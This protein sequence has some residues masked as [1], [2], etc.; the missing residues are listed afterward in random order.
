MLGDG[1]QAGLSQSARI[2]RDA[3]STAVDNR[4]V[5]DQRALPGCLIVTGV[6]GAGKT[7]TT[8]LVARRLR[9]AARIDGDD[10][11]MMIVSGNVGPVSEPADEAE[12]QLHLRA[13]N[14]CSLANN[15][16]AA[17]FAPIVDH[18][19]PDRAVLQL[20]IDNL[21][22]RPVMLVLL[23]PPLSV[24]ERRNVTRD[25][26]EQVDYDFSDLY[27]SMHAEFSGVGWTVDTSHIPPDVVAD[28]ILEQASQRAGVAGRVA[29]EPGWFSRR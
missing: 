8:R 26:Q 14:I 22:P 25:P 11:A 9:R 27:R 21:Q 6:P 18:V 7:T 17:G 13:R 29:R 3:S 12:R 28:A 19:I 4:P 1:D 5:T 10:V 2:T 15:F 24:C 23:A 16:H 20:M